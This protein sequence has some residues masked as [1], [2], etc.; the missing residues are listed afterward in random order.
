[1]PNTKSRKLCTLGEPFLPP[2]FRCRIPNDS[3]L[4][5][6]FLHGQYPDERATFE[7]DVAHFRMTVGKP[8]AEVTDADVCSYLEDLAENH[9][10]LSIRVQKARAVHSLFD[11]ALR[12]AFVSRNPAGSLVAP[13]R[14]SLT[15]EDGL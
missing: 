15:E 12:Q 14:G 7:C 13:R 4:V 5:A 6:S 3:A 11:F 8:L 10:A 9:V 1:M 2:P